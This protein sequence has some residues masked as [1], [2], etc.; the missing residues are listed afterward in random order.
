MKYRFPRNSSSLA[1]ISGAERR[2][3]SYQLNRYVFTVRQESR[4][5]VY[6]LIRIPFRLI[7][8]SWLIF[9]RATECAKDIGILGAC[10]PCPSI[11]G[12]AELHLS[13]LPT[14]FVALPT[15]LRGIVIWI[16]N[17]SQLT[18]AARDARSRETDGIPFTRSICDSFEF[19]SGPVFSRV[20]IAVATFL[21]I[22]SLSLCLARVEFPRA[23][24]ISCANIYANLKM[25]LETQFQKKKSGKSILYSLYSLALI[26]TCTLE[27]F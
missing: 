4:F 27:N 11:P 1:R 22:S 8:N 14:L 25:L 5:H 3:T 7:F 12:L 6:Q 13:P 15:H 21:A 19:I 23:T 18:S 24:G 9:N 17:P 10:T 16:S 26:F 2:L 20:S